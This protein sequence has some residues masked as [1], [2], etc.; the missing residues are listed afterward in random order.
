[1]EHETE[2]KARAEAKKAES[3][4]EDAKKKASSMAKDAKA[5]LK[6]DG[7]KLSDNR[8]NPVVLGNALIWGI[9]AI[10]ISYGAYQKHTEGKL[11]W[12]LAGSVAVVVGAFGVADYFGSKCVQ[13]WLCIRR[14]LTLVQ[15]APGEQVPTKIRD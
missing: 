1:M 10:A 2:D 12:Q 9:G 4:A 14:K 6:K 13:I 5:E 7:K 11:D 15:M 8:E 3:A